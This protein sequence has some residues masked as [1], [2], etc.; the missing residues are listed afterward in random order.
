MSNKIDISS[1]A[2]TASVAL[3]VTA[4]TANG[5]AVD[6]MG[7]Q[8]ALC[9]VE[10]VA[11]TDGTHVF[12][13]EDSDDNSTFADAA[14]RVDG[15]LPTITSA[16]TNGKAYAYTY[17]G[18]KRYLRWMVTVSGSPSTGCNYAAQIW[19]ANPKSVL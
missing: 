13:L 16:A 9:T 17:N 1:G 14:A 8:G 12:T 19:P 18:T 7:Y 2:G 15:T 3:G 10:I 11:W 4:A 5:T 6:L